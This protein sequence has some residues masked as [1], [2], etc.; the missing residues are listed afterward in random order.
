MDIVFDNNYDAKKSK[1]IIL[2]QNL[3]VKVICDQR[4]YQQ[5]DIKECSDYNMTTDKLKTS[6]TY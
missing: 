2:V 1:S 4:V 6:E 3:T 5:I